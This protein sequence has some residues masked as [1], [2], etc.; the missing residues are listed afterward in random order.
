MVSSTLVKKS[1]VIAYFLRRGEKEILVC[2]S[3]LSKIM[4]TEL[5]KK[6]EDDGR[7]A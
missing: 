6:E 2:P 5:T 1:D 3:R 7:D 4:T